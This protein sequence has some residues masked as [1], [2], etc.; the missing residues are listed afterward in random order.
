MIEKLSN[1]AHELKPS[2]PE[3]SVL[4]Q[5]SEKKK[6]QARKQKLFRVYFR[7][8]K[9][10]VAVVIAFMIYQNTR[11]WRKFDIAINNKNETTAIQCAKDIS[12]FF[13][14]AKNF[15]RAHDEQ[16]ITDIYRK[17]AGNIFGHAGSSNWVIAEKGYADTQN[18]WLKNNF[19]SA[20]EK[21]IVIRGHY[22]LIVDNSLPLIVSVSPKLDKALICI[23]TP[24]DL[25]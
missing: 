25:F 24:K 19:K 20:G 7:I 12:W 11:S 17:K 22:Q 21:W 4:L 9:I 6:Q 23:Q 10:S 1:D 14:P 16:I 13:I 18:L 8:V 15:L 3:V 2:D 5:K